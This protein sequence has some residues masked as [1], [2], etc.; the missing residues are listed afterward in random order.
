MKKNCQTQ[1]NQYKVTVNGQTY[2]KKVPLP[3]NTS[4]DFECMNTQNQE[5]KI[6]LAWSGH[7]GIKFNKTTCPVKN[8]EFTRDRQLQDNASYVLFHGPDFAH[9]PKQDQPANNVKRPYFQ[10]WIF[11]VFESPLNTKALNAIAHNYNGVFN[12]TATYLEESD[13]DGI[14]MLQSGIKL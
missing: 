11:S 7:Y 5:P 4:I 12:L 9:N 14:Y 6:I 2:P 8:C 1:T 13:F 3:Y 10:R